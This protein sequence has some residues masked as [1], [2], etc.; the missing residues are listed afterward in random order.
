MVA[1]IR[2]VAA[3]CTRD[4]RLSLR[5]HSYGLRQPGKRRAG[6]ADA[7]CVHADVAARRT[8][9][10]APRS[11]Q[12]RLSMRER[13][14]LFGGERQAPR[15]EGTGHF[16]RAFMDVARTCQWPRPRGRLPRSEERR[17]GKECVSP[18]KF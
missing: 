7:W 6:D 18:G 8:Y 13:F 10:G 16:L 4:R 9:P 12:L 15:L 14:G 5:R 11:W 2:G 1:N 3:I 17:V